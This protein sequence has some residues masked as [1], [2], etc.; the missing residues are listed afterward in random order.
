MGVVTNEDPVKLAV[1]VASVRP[2][3]VGPV[4]A[5]WF[6]GRVA[7]TPGFAA[8]TL[9][10][11]DFDLPVD[12]RSSAAGEKFAAAIDAA[13]AF[14]VVTPEYNH[15]YPASLKTALDSV[16]YEWRGKPIGFVSYGGMAGGLR[17]T[18]QLRQVVAELH[19]VSVRTSVGFHRVKK[20]F[21]AHGRTTD[22]VALDA[23]ATMLEQVRWWATAARAIRVEH[24]YPG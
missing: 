11:R 7:E 9:D 5:D 12:L 18:E 15:G 10:L 23:S 13:D 16:K 1:I 3:R 20:A 21:D 14:V 17:A 8:T 2:E 19:M 4:V 24:P 22:A 6:L